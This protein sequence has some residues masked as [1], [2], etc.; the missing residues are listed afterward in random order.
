MRKL[1]RNWHRVFLLLGAALAGCGDQHHPAVVEQSTVH[2]IE[3]MQVQEASL[4]QVYRVPGN[5]TADDSIQLSSRITGFIQSV[6]V[7][8]GDRVSQGD[9]L[10]EIDSADVQGAIRSAEAALASAQTD[11]EDAQRDVEQYGELARQG[12]IAADTLRKAKV[13]LELARS[14]INEA[15]AARETALA[16]LRYTSIRSPVDGVVIEL[17]KQSG[18]LATTGAPILLIE[19]QSS[20]VFQTYVAER[21]VASLYLGQKLAVELDALERPLNG[22]VLRIVPSGDP[23]TRRFEVKIALPVTAN[24]LPGM[25]GRA[26]FVTGSINGVVIPRSV[27]VERGGLEGVMVISGNRAHF[28]WLRIGQQWPQQLEVTAGL[29]AGELIVANPADDLFD[30]ALIELIT[31][32]PDAAD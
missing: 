8:E 24:L 2:P 11:L 23:V 17:H 14:Q 6:A 3:P 9:L 15:N 27:L 22:E 12:S 7:R 31:P 5:V 19:S 10:V 29:E 32:V 16:N 18:D 20:L 30:G 25:F 4:E 13:R 26:R 28:R 1:K 21:R